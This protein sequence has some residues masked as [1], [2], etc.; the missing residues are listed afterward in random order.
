MTLHKAETIID[1]QT[2]PL[3]DRDIQR[4]RQLTSHVDIIKPTCHVDRQKEK[5]SKCH[6]ARQKERK[7][8]NLT[9]RHRKKDSQGITQAQRKKESLPAMQADRKKVS[10]LTM[11]IYRKKD[12]L[13]IMYNIERNKVN[14]Q[15]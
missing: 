12:S 6:V 10:Q 15:C 11:Q 8:G 9:C 14:L 13:H 1:R 5:Q 4:L 7:T 2:T 3:S